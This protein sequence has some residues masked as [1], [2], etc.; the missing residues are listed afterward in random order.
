VSASLSGLALVGGGAV[1]LVDVG[2]D[3]GDGFVVL[4]AMR[5]PTSVPQ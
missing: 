2:E 3:L 1:E 5:S 4:G